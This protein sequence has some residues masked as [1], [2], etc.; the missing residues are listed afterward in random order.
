[1]VDRETIWSKMVGERRQQDTQLKV[2]TEGHSASEKT[3]SLVRTPLGSLRVPTWLSGKAIIFV[4]AVIVLGVIIKVQPFDRVEESNCLAMLVFCT[5][6]WATEVGLAMLVIPCSK[7]IVGNPLG[8]PPLR[9]EFLRTFP[10]RHSW[11]P[12]NNGRHRCSNAS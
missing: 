5:L 1:V 7:L 4:F 2:V 8:Y 11:C 6:L 3:H 12:S 9:D 10:Y